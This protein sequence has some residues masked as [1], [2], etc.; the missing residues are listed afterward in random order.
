MGELVRDIG[1]ISSNMELSLLGLGLMLDAMSEIGVGGNIG[2]AADD[3]G[4]SWNVWCGGETEVASPEESERNPTSAFC[5]FPYLFSPVSSSTLSIS[6]EVLGS[7]LLVSLPGLSWATPT[8]IGSLLGALLVA[9]KAS[10]S[11]CSF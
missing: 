7:P 3:N 10:G 4:E 1:L 5:R 6:D 8:T 2:K 9:T 11:S